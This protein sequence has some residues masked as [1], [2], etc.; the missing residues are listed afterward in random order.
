MC[1]R[2]GGNKDGTGGSK[3]VVV[4]DVVVILTPK[5]LPYEEKYAW[6]KTVRVLNARL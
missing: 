5:S 2:V 4:L 1:E 3:A 6:K